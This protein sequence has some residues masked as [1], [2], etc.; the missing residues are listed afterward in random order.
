MSTGAE[1]QAPGGGGDLGG[2]GQRPLVKEGRPA[3]ED[4][5]SEE[6]QHPSPS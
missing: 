5:G 2:E 6:A 1:G 4:C 3:L